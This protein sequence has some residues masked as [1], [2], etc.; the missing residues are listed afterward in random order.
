MGLALSIALFT[1]VFAVMGWGSLL[2]DV[3]A[4]ILYPFQWIGGKISGAVEGFTHYFED[5]DELREEAESLRQENESLRSDLL[6]AEITADELAWLYRYLS[7]KEEHEDYRMCVAAVVSSS[8]AAGA[9]GDFVTEITLNKG[10]SS[11][12]EAGMPVVT[13]AGLIGVVVETGAY[14]CRV[15]TILDPS[16][17][18]GAITTR[19]NETGLCEGDY[20]HVQD[21]RL[22]LRYM[23]EEADVQPEDIVITGGQGSVYPYG[24]PIGRVERVTAN[25]FSR[26]TEAVIV[27]FA[28]F[29]DLSQVMILTEYVHTVA[30]DE[31]ETEEGE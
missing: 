24:I 12:I 2:G 14:H 4:A 27:P 7:M 8:S 28:D 26:T 23:A 20:A 16:V 3:G 15:S 21:G 19:Q 11:G 30:P 13:E 29:S 1:G 31:T 10:T 25:A 5:M 17:S 9:G 22:L 6:E 18:V